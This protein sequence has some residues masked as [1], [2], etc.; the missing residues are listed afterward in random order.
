[1]STWGEAAVQP[2]GLREDQ[3]MY[4]PQA[5]AEAGNSQMQACIRLG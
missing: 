5:Q 2:G 4:G 3:G 1:M